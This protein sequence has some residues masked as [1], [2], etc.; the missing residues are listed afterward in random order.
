MNKGADIVSKAL[1]GVEACTI[2]IKGKPYFV[3]PFTVKQIAGIGLS[4]SGFD[5]DGNTLSDLLK[6]MTD[7]EGAAKALS[8]AVAGD[9][10]KYEEFLQAPFG[11]V[12]EALEKCLSLINIQ[13]F[14]R[15]SGLSR[16]VR[17]LIANPKL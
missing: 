15:L 4:L 1:L 6:A 3:K 12:V 2:V 17:L 14:Q 13:D 9:E 11:E 16:S 5:N 10:S 7:T 8:Y